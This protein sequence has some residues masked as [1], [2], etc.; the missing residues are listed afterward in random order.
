M[1]I[2]CLAWEHAD[3]NQRNL[4]W[5][6][7]YAQRT[8]II[9]AITS[10]QIGKSLICMDKV[11]HKNK[12]KKIKARFKY[13]WKNPDLFKTIPP[14]PPPTHH[15]NNDNSSKKN[16]SS[17]DAL[18]LPEMRKSYN[19]MLTARFHDIANWENMIH[20]HILHH[21]TLTWELYIAYSPVNHTIIEIT[22]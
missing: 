12:N 14:L 15:R 21:K 13:L 2:T 9:E 6:S 18:T 17:N 3:F 11:K 7:R 8:M 22:L 10:Y 16:L 19:P 20:V 1:R 4:I 5:G